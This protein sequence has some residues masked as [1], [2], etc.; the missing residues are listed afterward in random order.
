MEVETFRFV[1]FL[2][3]KIGFIIIIIIIIIL[4]Y[5]LNQSVLKLVVIKNSLL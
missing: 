2:C 5:F 4:F 1:T 3:P